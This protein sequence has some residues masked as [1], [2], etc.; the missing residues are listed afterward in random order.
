MVD[1]YIPDRGDLVWINFNPS[2]GREQ[3]GRRPAVVLSPAVH[4][5]PSE[6]AVLLPVTSK[7][8]GYPME[9]PLPET[10]PIQ[11]VILCDQIK[12][13]DWRN[14]NVE[15]IGKIDTETLHHI[16]LKLEPLILG[17]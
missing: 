9:V 8:K 7:R 5:R 14:R 15:F 16:G 6:L 10:L 3:Q 11:G 13:L 1:R 12:S 2:V 4:N 17:R